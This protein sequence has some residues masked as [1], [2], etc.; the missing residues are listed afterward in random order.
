MNR[1]V[2]N[3]SLIPH[4]SSL[5][6]RCRHLLRLFAG[7]FDSADH[8]KCLFGHIVAFAFQNFAET[9][10]GVFRLDV[11]AFQARKLFADRERL[12]EESLD[13]SGSCNGLFVVF[14][15]FI[16][17]ENCDNILQI[18]VALQ[19]FLD[20]LRGVVML[21]ANNLRVENSRV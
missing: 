13:F 7:L 16:E 6:S 1:N 21:I 9:F 10:D 2:L 11:F 12:R 4:P 17:S 8:I 14:A 18:F 5:L 19:D 20:R 15:Q 3:S